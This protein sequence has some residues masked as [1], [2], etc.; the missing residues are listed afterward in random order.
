MI[1]FIHS[2]VEL[3][4]AVDMADEGT[5]DDDS[6]SSE[7][8][9]NESEDSQPVEL[10]VTGREQRKTAG[11]RYDRDQI[12]E[13]AAEEEEPDEVTLLF[14]AEEG[15][16]DDEFRSDAQ[17]QMRCPALMTKIKVP[18]PVERSLKEKKNYKDRLK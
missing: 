12:L 9:D 14:A 18:M 2:I 15:E 16:E 1:V 3:H 4:P 17:M 5:R 6:N 13:E 8:S 7:S 11:N 10:L